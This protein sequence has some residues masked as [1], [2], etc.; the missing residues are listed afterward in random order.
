MNQSNPEFWAFLIGINIGI[1]IK[2]VIDTILKW[3]NI[4]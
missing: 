2:I 3:L 4:Q 1:I